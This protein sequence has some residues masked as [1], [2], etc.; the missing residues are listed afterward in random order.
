M[1]LTHTGTLW[2][3]SMPGPLQQHITWAL[4]RL[5]MPDGT[6][7]GRGIWRSLRTESSLC[8]EVPFVADAE[9]VTSLVDNLSRWPHLYFELAQDPTVDDAGMAVDGMRYCHTPELGTFA[10]QT[11]AAGNIVVGEDALRSIAAQGGDIADA[12][13]LA[14]AGPWDRVLEPMRLATAGF[15][16]VE[17]EASESE[18]A[19]PRGEVTAGGTNVVQFYPRRAAM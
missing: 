15:E 17:G 11:D 8:A 18:M 4:A 2:I 13:D 7:P 6:K 5:S 10:G 1:R 16:P 3:H 12:I 14:I 9:A 19:P